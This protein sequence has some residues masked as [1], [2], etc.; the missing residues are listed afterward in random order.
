MNLKRQFSYENAQYQEKIS[1]IILLQK[2][3]SVQ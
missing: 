2:L 3:I 1:R